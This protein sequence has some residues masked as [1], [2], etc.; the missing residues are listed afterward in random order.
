RQRRAAGR[1]AHRRDRDPRRRLTNEGMVNQHWSHQSV[2]Q[3]LAQ[4]YGVKRTAS[5]QYTYLYKQTPNCAVLYQPDSPNGSV[6]RAPLHL[7]AEATSWKRAIGVAIEPFTVFHRRDS[8]KSTI[9][10]WHQ[11][12]DWDGFANAL[13]LRRS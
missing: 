10:E 6:R 11:V 3:E 7:R 2:F 9:F 4:R 1:L 13:G 12:T 5:G 8:G